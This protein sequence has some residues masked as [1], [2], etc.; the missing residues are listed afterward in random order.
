M[1]DQLDALRFSIVAAVQQELTRYS[2][3]VSTEVQRLRDDIAAERSA[4]MRTDEQLRALAPVLERA[5]AVS[6]SVGPE[7]EQALDERLGEFS[8]QNK[9]RY[10]ELDARI[11]RVADEA[12]VGLVAAVESAARPVVKQLEHRQDRVEADLGTFD[13]S[14][15]KFDDQAARMVEH[16]NAVIEATETRMDEVSAQVAD[17]IGA[18]LASLATRL[19]DVSA[20]AARQQA[21]VSNAV[22]ARVDQA[23]D[24]INDRIL[25][26]EA[27]IN[28]NM[29]QRV[30]DID[31]YVGRV[32]AGLDD[33]VTM[34]SDRIGAA[35]A[36]FAEVDGVFAALDQRLAGLDVDAIDEMKDRVAGIAGEIELLRI[37][38]E[39]FQASMGD[40]MDKTVIR[41]AEVEAAMQEHYMDVS[42]AVQLDRLEEVE[43]ALIAL[44]PDQFVRRTDVATAPPPA[45]A[46]PPAPPALTAPAATNG[47]APFGPPV[48]AQH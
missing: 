16:F 24:R 45:P 46:A 5:S 36:R 29:G 13:R 1:T 33:A 21:E 14:L 7:L 40:T 27:R 17:E 9:R 12:T 39:R 22:G 23:E 30:A 43:R 2:Q 44:D 6:G 4:R 37:E 31:A 11:G 35:D 28:E 26:A 48:N 42:T 8:V 10:D 18:R 15:R 32:S 3:Q 19:D 47:S 20:Q 34:L 25:T 38:V 41:I